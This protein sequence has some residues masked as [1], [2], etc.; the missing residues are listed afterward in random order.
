[1]RFR[2]QIVH[3]SPTKINGRKSSN[4][5][6]RSPR[7]LNV[8][9]QRVALGSRSGTEL[10]NESAEVDLKR[11]VVDITRVPVER[12][13]EEAPTVRTEGDLTIVPVV[14][15]RFVIVKQFFIKEELHIRHRTE[16]ETVKETVELRRQHAV[17]VR[18]DSDGRIIEPDEEPSSRPVAEPPIRKVRSRLVSAWPKLPSDSDA[19]KARAL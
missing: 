16:R 9:F 5:L 4:Y 15:E 10:R 19:M 13:V 7:L 18:L 12:L 14:E 3:S 11:D 1:M 2:Q 8:V 6:K 17:V